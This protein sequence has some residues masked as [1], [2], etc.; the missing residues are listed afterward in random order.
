MPKE[1]Y[2]SIPASPPALPSSFAAREGREGRAGREGRRQSRE[3]KKGKITFGLVAFSFF[4]IL[5][6]V[7]TF[8]N[9]TF[10][11]IAKLYC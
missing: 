7:L 2:P 5:R 10:I 6:T 3:R 8:T 9:R 4:L 1:G 11:R